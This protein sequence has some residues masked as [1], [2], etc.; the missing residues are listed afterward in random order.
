RGS[1]VADA[2]DT[3]A[4]AERRRALAVGGAVQRGPLG[5]RGRHVRAAGGRGGL[6]GGAVGRAGLGAELLDRPARGLRAAG[7]AVEQLTLDVAGLQV[8]HPEPDGVAQAGAAAV[9]A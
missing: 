3:R 2:A 8:A 4:A 5:R 1:A 9:V 7:G 6:L